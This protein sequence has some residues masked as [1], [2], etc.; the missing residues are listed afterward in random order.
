MEI[1]R[2]LELDPQKVY[3]KGE[4]MSINNPRKSKNNGWIYGTSYDNRA[5]FEE[6]LNK[7]LDVLE[8]KMSILK[9]YAKKYE[10][11]FSCAIF[12]L[13]DLP[14]NPVIKFNQRYN[15]FVREVDAEFDFDI[16]YPPLL[17]ESHIVYE[18]D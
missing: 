11:E 13:E 12:L 16:Y 8:P 5:S 9:G 18:E 17:D 1:S 4:P 6:Q 2:S 3:V 7:I 10:C 15:D 14:S